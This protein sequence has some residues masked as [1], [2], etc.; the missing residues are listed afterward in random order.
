LV[1]IKLG[2][3]FE[4]DVERRGCSCTTGPGFFFSRIEPFATRA[5]AASLEEEEELAAVANVNKPTSSL[6]LLDLLLV[7]QDRTVFRGL[8]LGR[9]AG[10]LSLLISVIATPASLLCVTGS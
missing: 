4:I 6:L 9:L 10:E 3:D 1:E 2:L 8:S 5:D 7:E